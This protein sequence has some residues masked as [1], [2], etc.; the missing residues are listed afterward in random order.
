MTF[1]YFISKYLKFT[2]IFRTEQ[3]SCRVTDGND[4]SHRN[5]LSSHQMTTSVKITANINQARQGWK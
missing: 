5:V 2:E 3:S 4:L 1:T